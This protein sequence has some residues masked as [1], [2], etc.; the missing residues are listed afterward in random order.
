MNILWVI[1]QVVS[2]ILTISTGLFLFD[3]NEKR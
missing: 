3:N 1:G 2:F